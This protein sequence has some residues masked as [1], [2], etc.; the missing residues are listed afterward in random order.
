MGGAGGTYG[1]CCDGTCGGPYCGC[2]GGPYD[3]AVQP[4]GGPSGE[5]PSG[6]CQGEGPVTGE[7]S[8]AGAPHHCGVPGNRAF[9]Q[10]GRLQRVDRAGRV[11]GRALADPGAAGVR[12]PSARGYRRHRAVHRNNHLV[13]GRLVDRLSEQRRG[14]HLHIERRERPAERADRVP[15]GDD[16]PEHRIVGGPPDPAP[17]VPRALG[18]RVERTP[19]AVEELLGAGLVDPEPADDDH[20][21]HSCHYVLLPTLPVMRSAGVAN[22]Q[23]MGPRSA[24][25][26]AYLTRLPRFVLVLGALAI[27]LG[28]L[29]APGIIGA[30]LLAVIAALTGWL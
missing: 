19:G 14:V 11:R 21:A 27:L 2:C 6:G 13:R 7:S 15:F 12:R 16:R 28:G 4:C 10:A 5:L 3:G 9:A 30:L 1:G 18:A 29:F 8:Q 20:A 26:V 25:L 17:Q 23:P 24:A 22:P